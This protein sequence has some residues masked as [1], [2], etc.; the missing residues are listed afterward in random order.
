MDFLGL[1]PKSTNEDGVTYENIIVVIDRLTKYAE[2]ILLPRKSSTLYLAK[3]FIK[4]VVTRHGIPKR[5]I[6]NR[7]RKFTSYF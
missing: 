7:D 6:S 4:H 5:I 2:F 1:L 3:V